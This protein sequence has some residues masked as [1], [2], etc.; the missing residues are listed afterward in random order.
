M[1]HV[2]PNKKD[3]NLLI[4]A[5]L[6]IASMVALSVAVDAWGG[7][8]S[9]FS[10]IEG[11]I[12]SSLTFSNGNT[13]TLTVENNGTAPSEI[14]E[15]EINNEKQTFTMNSTT[16]VIL[17]KT[18]VN[19]SIVYEYTNGTSYHIK[20]VSARGNTYL[21]TATACGNVNRKS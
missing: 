3:V 15:I 1:A 8:P 12:P 18:A 6:L 20:M 11:L 13:I 5:V 16:D 19:I 4:G 7:K 9:Q 10:Q 17:P 2:K 14:A 21:F